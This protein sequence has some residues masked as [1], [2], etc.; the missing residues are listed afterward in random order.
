MNTTELLTITAAIVPDRDA[1]IFD[2]R[3]FTY[4]ELMDR[5]N[6]L[7]NGLADLGVQPGDRIAAM[8][9]NCNEHIEAYFA[10]TKLDCIFVPINF[11]EIRTT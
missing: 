3:R 11:I 6:R 8:Q 5:V 7:A 2:D 4:G 9:V 10:A 1:I